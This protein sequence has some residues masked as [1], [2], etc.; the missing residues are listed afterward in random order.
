MI[1]DPTGRFAQRPFYEPGELDVECE[2]LAGKF[3]REIRGKVEYPFR[4]DDLTKLLERH[5]EDFDPYSTLAADYGDGV[6]GVTEFTPGSKPTVRIDAAL[7]NDVA[8]ENRLRTTLTHELGHAK[9]HAWLFDQRDGGGLFPNP[10]RKAEVQV[11]KRENILNAPQL[12]WMEWQAG[13]ICGAILMP[14]G[15]VRKFA[16]ELKQSVPPPAFEPITAELEY[17]A[18]LVQRIVEAFQ[19]SRDAAQVRLHRLGIFASISLNRFG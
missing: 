3:L 14:A 8:R 13:H 6:E 11:C 19:V 2:V 10:K 1:A 16:Q 7:S 17:G 18:V 9:Y 12:D 15:R 4:T 5:V